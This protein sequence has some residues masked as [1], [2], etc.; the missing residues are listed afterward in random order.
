[1]PKISAKRRVFLVEDHPITREGF[2]QLLNYQDDLVVCGQAGTVAAALRDI[3]DAQPDLIIMDVSL[4]DGHGIELVKDLQ[5][6]YPHLR[7]LML[8]MHDESLYAERA[9]QAGARGYVMKQE[10]T[11]TVMTAIRQVLQDETYLSTKMQRII[12]QRFAGKLPPDQVSE[13]EHLT[14]RE[15]EVL[16]LIGRG[17]STSQIARQLR[18]SISTVETHRAHLKEKLHTQTGPELVRRAIEWVGRSAR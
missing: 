12:V 7:I 8:S 9:L 6:R 11:A 10:A 2:A 1:M 17:Q 14:D 3:P 16:E 15:L 4:P 5:T 18:I 13:M